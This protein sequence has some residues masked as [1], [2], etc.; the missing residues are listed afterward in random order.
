MFRLRD[1]QGFI[2]QPLIAFIKVHRP[3][4]LSVSQS[5][6]ASQISM[7]QSEDL[8]AELSDEKLLGMASLLVDEGLGSFDRCYS[9]VRTL[10]GNLNKTREEL[11]QLIFYECQF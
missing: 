5:Q 1:K 2:G 11:S 9:L 7:K 6:R 3:D 10:R 8:Y 4:S